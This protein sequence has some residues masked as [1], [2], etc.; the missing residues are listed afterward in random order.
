MRTIVI[1]ACAALI[2]GCASLPPTIRGVEYQ[3]Y[4]YG[5]IVQLPDKGWTLTK[6]VPDKF[7]AYLVPEA[8]ERALLLLHNPQTGGLIAVQAGTLSLSYESILTL[9]ERL[10]EFVEPFLDIDWLL[11]VQDD[12]EARSSYQIYQCDAS[13]L[14]WQ[15]R[16]G[17]RPL[18]GITHA[19]RGRVYPLKGETCYATFYLF[20]DQE[21]LDDNLKVLYRMAGS[22][23]SGEVF[24][25]NT[26]GW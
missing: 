24:T 22:F 6:S 5:F 19:S 2:L 20:S 17:Q 12:P 23:Q 25:T 15:E 13:G 7:A 3:N 8:P 10:T 1:L 16:A 26:Y 11:I 9:Q 21:T 14:Y 18:A 4:R